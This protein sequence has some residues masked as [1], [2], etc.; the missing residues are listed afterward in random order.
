MQEGDIY[1]CQKP[2]LIYFFSNPGLQ[3]YFSTMLRSSSSGFPPLFPLMKHSLSLRKASRS[4]PRLTFSNCI[5]SDVTLVS[6][7]LTTFPKKTIVFYCP[8]AKVPKNQN[9]N[10]EQTVLRSFK[11]FATPYCLLVTSTSANVKEFQEFISSFTTINKA[12]PVIA[13]K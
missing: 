6:F 5:Q 2:A 11:H 9:A 8:T 4:N 12:T 10:F 13:A 1:E 3:G 7:C